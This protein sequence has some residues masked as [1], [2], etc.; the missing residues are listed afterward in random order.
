MLYFLYEFFNINFFQYITVRAGFSF[1]IAFSL[2][3]LIMPYFIKW[4]KKKKV[5]QP[6]F[7]LAPKSHQQ[8]SNTPTMGGLVFLFSTIISI[9]LSARLDNSFVII[10]IICLVGFSLI[11]LKDDLSKI[12]G[13]SNQ[14]GLN[15]KAKI[16]LQIF[17]SFLISTL[18][19]LFTSTT[20][21]IY[22]PFYKYAIY[23]DGIF[24]ILFWTLVFVSASN[25]VNLTDGLDGLATVPSIFSL[26][27]LSVFMYVSG[28]AVF[29]SYLLVPKITNVG[30]VVILSSALIGSLIGFL[31][32]NCYPAEVFMGDSGSL[33]LGGF[34]GYCAIISKNEILLLLIGFVFVMETISVVLQVTSFKARKKRVFLM[35]PIHHHFEMKGWAENKIIIRFWLIAFLANIL[36]LTALKI[37]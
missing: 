16:I 9:I 34:L 31:W 5:N 17:I 28:H 37:R 12:T 21:D 20:H 13:K 26:A 36:A 30:E 10:A 15:P 11:G 33:S 2:S 4:A 18:L 27:T 19:Y 6:I 24:I 32:Y 22:V 1:I 35:A 23:K 8:K 7:T 3:I 14:A 25:A 29:S